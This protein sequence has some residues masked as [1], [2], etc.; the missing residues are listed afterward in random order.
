MSY[1]QALPTP[2]LKLTGIFKDFPGTR[3]L[4]GVDFE[5]MSGEVH[6]L[7]G[8]NG[9]GK[10]TTLKIISGVLRPDAGSISLVDNLIRL[11]SPSESL[12][13]GIATVYQDINLVP[14]LSVEQNLLLGLDRVKPERSNKEILVRAQEVLEALHAPFSLQALIVDLDYA[15]KQ[16][17]QIARAVALAS[18]VLLLDEPTEGLSKPQYETLQML[19]LNLRD[20][21]IGIVYV[22][23]R[24]QEVMD[25]ADRITVLRDGT[26]VGTLS[27]SEATRGELIRM[28]V[29]SKIT[30][31]DAIDSETTSG[32]VV[33]QVSHLA[34]QGYFQ[35]ISL[36]V[37]SGEIVG[38]AGVPGS[39][40]AELLK[41]ICGVD[42]H[43][44]G[45]IT[46]DGQLCRPASPSEA[47]EKGIF[48]LPADRKGEGLVLPASIRTNIILPKAEGLSTFGVRRRRKEA[49]VSQDYVE[50]LDIRTP[51]IETLTRYLSGGNQQKV[52]F[53]RVLHSGAKVI[54]LDEPT[55]GVDIAGKAEIHELIKTLAIQG[56]AILVASSEMDE[57]ISICHRIL[58]LRTGDLVGEFPRADVDPEVILHLALP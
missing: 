40:K 1:S 45:N 36:E 17:V 28:M 42:P 4:D 2:L 55:Q 8:E 35:D 54:L 31:N 53:A 26:R 51:G 16:F 12:E 33:L 11:N 14:L 46:V 38:L 43:D 3:A 13:K 19:L 18:R 52:L 41:S 6:A 34:R 57:L 5:L 48:Y 37:H 10:S 21:G 20:Q 30:N 24:L 49:S 29:G 44:A 58:V 50:R 47:V 56:A 22:S 39:R 15:G 23:H 27:K 25:I 32:N 7:V 9:S